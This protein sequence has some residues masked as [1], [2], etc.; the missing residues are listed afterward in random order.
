MPGIGTPAQD[1]FVT[2]RTAEL[3]GAC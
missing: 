2:Q 1:G 3:H